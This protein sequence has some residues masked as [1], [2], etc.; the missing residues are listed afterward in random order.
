MATADRYSVVLPDGRIVN[1]YFT[2]EESDADRRFTGIIH[3]DIRGFT[4]THK[5][6]EVPKDN[7]NILYI[8]SVGGLR[9]GSGKAITNSQKSRWLNGTLEHIRDIYDEHNFVADPE[10]VDPMGGKDGGASGFDPFEVSEEVDAN[11][12]LSTLLSGRQERGQFF[13]RMSVDPVL[14]GGGTS[15]LRE[16]LRAGFDPVDAAF[17]LKGLLA[18]KDFEWEHLGGGGADV[19]PRFADFAG[20]IPSVDDIRGQLTELVRRRE[21]GDSADGLSDSAE[22]LLESEGRQANLIRAATNL[23]S[24]PGFMR[25]AIQDAIAKKIQRR[26]YE[27]P[28]ADLLNQFVNSGFRL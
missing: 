21:L 27:A 11:D 7:P 6:V 2:G 17:Q 26:Q 15:L 13:D 8:P 24:T 4:L 18:P 3:R 1:I 22:G 12:L 16:G 28:G 9:L 25:T 14:K 19:L 23:R 20:G 5:D 10:T